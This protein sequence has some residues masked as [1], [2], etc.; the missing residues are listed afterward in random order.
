LINKSWVAR[1]VIFRAGDLVQVYRSDLDFTFKTERK[2]LPKFSAPRRVLNRNQNSYQLET[3]EGFPIAGKF[4]S[5]RLRLF[6]PR[7]GTGL[8]NIQGAIEEEWQKRED[9][10]DKVGTNL[11]EGEDQAEVEGAETSGTQDDTQE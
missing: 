5:R 1:E 4:S 2:I 6:V 11:V 10:E 7:K 8:D 9:A 3:L